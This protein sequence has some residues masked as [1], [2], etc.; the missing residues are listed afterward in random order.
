MGMKKFFLKVCDYFFSIKREID[1]LVE[2]VE[3]I[4]NLLWNNDSG[5]KIRLQD[6]RYLEA[7]GFKVYSEND[8]DG[9]IE[10]I[11]NRIGSKS[12][13]FIE[14]GVQDGL[15]SNCHYL[16]HKGWRGCW[17]EGDESYCKQIQKNFAKPIADGRLTIKNA[18]IDKDNIDSLIRESINQIGIDAEENWECDLLS[19]DIDGN[20]YWVWQAIKCISPRVVVIEYNAKFPAN[21]EWIMEYDAKHRWNYDDEQGASLKA[22]EKLGNRLG[23]QLVGTNARGVNAFFVRKDLAGDKFALP[24]TSEN[25]YNSAKYYHRYRNGHPSKKYIGK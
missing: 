12:K 20:D 10:E 9:I 14:F 6:P 2:K 25:L 19:I 5:L 24:A 17:I 23:Y 16:L 13:M 7:Y 1:L 3:G 18:F 8:E 15:E 4:E 21:F 11:F 22:Y